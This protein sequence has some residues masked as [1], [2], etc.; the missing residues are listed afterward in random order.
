MM[1][2]CFLEEKFVMSLAIG[3]VCFEFLEEKS[4]LPECRCLLQDQGW[5]SN[6]TFL[7]NLTIHLHVLNVKLQGR[8]KL[9]NNLTNNSLFK[10]RVKL[11]FTLLRDHSKHIK[12]QTENHNI[13]ISKY[14]SKINIFQIVLNSHFS[15]ILTEVSN[16][17]LFTNPLSIPE[18]KTDVLDTNITMEVTPLKCKQKFEELPVIPTADDTIKF[19]KLLPYENFPNLRKSVQQCICHFASIYL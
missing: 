16:I 18:Q 11:F 8:N 9:L 15:G 10:F 3:R 2:G 4:E 13:N 1:C 17:S 12:S 6:L 19:W 14:I 7:V 5:L